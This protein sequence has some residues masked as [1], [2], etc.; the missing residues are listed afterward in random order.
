[1]RRR[2]GPP[3]GE[4]PRLTGM[5]Q[6]DAQGQEE[7]QPVDEVQALGWSGIAV[8]VPTSSS[9][10]LCPV[11]GLVVAYRHG[12]HLISWKHPKCHHE[13]RCVCSLGSVGRGSGASETRVAIRPYPWRR[14][15]CVSVQAARSVKWASMRN[16]ER[17]GAETAYLVNC[18]FSFSAFLRYY[19]RH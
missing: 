10:A 2:H 14:S 8:I 7:F 5:H 16:M 6:D 17:S 1:M 3:T 15:F 11:R 4:R 18:R 19:N 12:F 9:S 13:R